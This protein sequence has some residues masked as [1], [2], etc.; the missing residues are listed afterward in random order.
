MS[1]RGATLAVIPAR[2]G[3]RGLPGKL[4]RSLGG[5]PVLA[6]TVRAASVAE[7]IDHALVSTDDPRIRRTAIVWG[8]DA[9]FLRPAPLS[10][11]DA[12][13]PPVIRHAVE[14]FE[15]V[16]GRPVEIAVTL[17]PTSPLRTGAEIDAA[18]GLL[19][20]AS[21]DS[22]VS[23]APIGMPTSVLGWVDSGRWRS[24]APGQDDVRRQ[25]S[26]PAMRL[27]GGIYVSRRALIAE[28]RLLG[29]R[30]GTIVVAEESAIDIDAHE[31]LRRARAAVRRRDP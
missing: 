26:P 25:A 24:V 2:G 21:L 28:D 11:D 27:T 13:T 7:R 3:S 5:I 1:S 10:T 29:D 30:V 8:A 14:W 17:Q 23:I 16:T 20:D 4:L 19:E 12:P 18:V 15:R 9:P 22:A 6:H 31:D